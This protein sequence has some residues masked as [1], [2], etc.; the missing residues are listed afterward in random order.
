MFSYLLF[1]FR[2]N[3]VAPFYYESERNLKNG[4]KSCGFDYVGLVECR[5]ELIV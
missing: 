3:T 2:Q 1:Q 5:G 4:G